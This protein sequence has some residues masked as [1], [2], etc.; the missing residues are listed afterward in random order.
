MRYGIACGVTL[1]A[2][3]LRFVLFGHLDTR[4][5]YAFFLLGVMVV[6]WYGGLGPAL[7]A[8]VA[9]LLLGGYFFLPRTGSSL[10]MGDAERTAILIYVINGSLVSFLMDNLHARIKKLES[11]I[12]QIADKQPD[13][14]I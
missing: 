4:I 14:E 10:A 12:S 1:A 3:L 6:A 2:F 7:F 11:E 13:A 5:P 9:G 8:V